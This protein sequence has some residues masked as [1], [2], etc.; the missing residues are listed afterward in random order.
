VFITYNLYEAPG[1]LF[2][3]RV[4]IERKA[5]HNSKLRK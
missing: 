5:T 2:V 4:N 1:T 3:G